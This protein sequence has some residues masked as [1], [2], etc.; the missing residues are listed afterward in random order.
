VT[1]DNLPPSSTLYSISYNNHAAKVQ[2]TADCRPTTVLPQTSRGRLHTAI[3]GWA[4]L[5]VYM[6]RSFFLSATQPSSIDRYMAF[7]H[8]SLS[9]R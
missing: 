4:G 3:T 9:L 6:S 2:L 8:L 1:T 5:P 7:V